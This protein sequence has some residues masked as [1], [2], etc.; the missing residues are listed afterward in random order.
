MAQRIYCNRKWRFCEYFNEE[1]LLEQLVLDCKI[2]DLPH[3]IKETPFSYFDESIYQMEA[4]YQKSIFAPQQWEGMVVELVFEGVGHECDVY[5]NGTHVG[6]HNCGYTAI[7]LDV[8]KA[9][10]F[11]QDNLITVRVDSREDLNQPP[12]GFV[13]DYMTFG[14]IYRDV[15]FEVK[16]KINIEDIFYKPTLLEKVST[17]KKTAAQIKQI[18]TPA[19]IKS[20]VFFSEDV[21]DAAME[22]RVFIKQYLDNEL[23]L[24]APVS[25]LE[26]EGRKNKITLT[27]AP[28]Q[29]NLW[30]V[31]S[32]RLYTVKTE[33]YLDDVLVD[34]VEGTVGFRSSEFRTEG[35]FLN[36]RR[37]KI[38]GLNRHQSY[39]YVGYAM[40]ESMQRYDAKILK[41]ELCCNAV[42]TSHYPQSQYFIDECD[43][44]GLLVFTEMPGWQHI[45]GEEWK[46]VAVNNVKDMVIQ[47]RN[48]PSIILWGVRINESPDDDDFYI[49]TNEE[50]HRFD[51]TRPTGGVRC[52]PKSN[53]LEDVYTYNDFV[54][55]G[56][57]EGCQ[58]KKNITSDESRP[59][60]ISEYGGHMF[61][62]KLF[63][64]EEHRRD[65]MMRHAKVLND[66]ASHDDIAGSF[67]WCMFD[68]N[69]HKDFGSGDRICYHGVLDMFRN[70]KLAASV[71]AACGDAEPV[72]E[73]SS[74]FD[75]GEHPACNRGD[76][77]I[78]S[79]GD[80]VRM[81]KNDKLI[82]EY[83]PE[84]SSFKN[85]KHGPIL[86]DDYIGDA[87]AEGENFKPRQAALVKEMLNIAATKG[88]SISLRLAVIAAQLIVLYHMDP[89]D[90]VPLYNK[91]VGDWGGEAKE[92]RFEAI[93][94]N[95]VVKTVVKS[96]MTKVQ[97]RPIVSQTLLT[98]LHG[99][100]VAQVRL[101]A[102]D[103]HGNQL[104]FYNEPVTFEVEG[105]IE[106]IGP[107]AT[108]FRGG[109]TGVYIKSR[110][111][112]GNG[113]L[114][115]KCG[116]M[117]P[118][119]I[120]F[121]VE[122]LNKG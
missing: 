93:K 71:Y 13:I 61:P 111:E 107:E 49:R 46:D 9:L 65:H 115:I 116:E 28:I 14:G 15:Y 59:Y 120:A 78:I 6:Y 20:E 118:I 103:E 21:A 60:L 35:Y 104:S 99:Y 72:L 87:I 67:G 55:S 39:P 64:D 36:G 62:T 86:I 70:P 57:N 41:E 42:R 73:V 74:S 24:S 76:T 2:V 26:E 18:T 109:A 101:S 89:K 47:Y 17:R 23:L 68:Y 4:C 53:L 51:P 29:V 82:K 40:P 58:P 80:Q 52:I 27:S 19:I 90:A 12:F 83:I 84:D 25:G 45:G 105:P 91:Y 97:I 94:N 79:N 110:G 3:T 95:E 11:G 50:A 96:A 33:L 30:D 98:E 81:Y 69:T 121:S 122:C 117:N 54:H 108:A 77:Y 38:R 34:T 106:V 112:D 119:A 66:V 75:I 7:R 1:M 22:E 100:D 113:R 32:P 56:D 92:Y 63:D 48:H 114:I 37:L 16:N 85:L 10:K 88:Y 102:C 8:T 5:V 44:L 43:R 31:E